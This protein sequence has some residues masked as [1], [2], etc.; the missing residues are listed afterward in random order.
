[1]PADPSTSSAPARTL[2]RIV[3]VAAVAAL[4]VVVY[5]TATRLV[6]AQRLRERTSDAAIPTVTIVTAQPAPGGAPLELPGRVE[7]FARAPIYAR[8]GGYL[9]AWYVDI[10]TRVRAGQLLAEIETPDLDQQL[11]QA[12]AELA[13]AEASAALAGSTAKRWQSLLAGDSVSQQ[14]VEEKTADL[15]AR[16]AEVRALRANVDR[17]PRRC[18]QFTRIVAPFDGVVTAPGNRRRRADQRRQ[19]AGPGA[20][21]RLRP[22]QAPRL[23]ERTAELHSADPPGRTR[24]AHGP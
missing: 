8:V 2:R 4:V 22:G 16:Q 14:E 21:R 23:R 13:N 10:G 18:K 9:K 11:L 19:R 6:A 7:A 5:G 20:V 15:A 3:A 17:L 1:M 24:D 12:E